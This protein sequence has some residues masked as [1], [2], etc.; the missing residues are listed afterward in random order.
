MG[1]VMIS[2]SLDSFGSDNVLDTACLFMPTSSNNN[3]R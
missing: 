3:R 2:P 1:I